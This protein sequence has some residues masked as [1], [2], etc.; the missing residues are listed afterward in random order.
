MSAITRAYPQRLK[1]LLIF[2]SL[3]FAHF[4][5]LVKLPAQ[6]IELSSATKYRQYNH[7]GTALHATAWQ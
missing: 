4:P 2:R 5:T 6:F 1:F 3:F 7:N